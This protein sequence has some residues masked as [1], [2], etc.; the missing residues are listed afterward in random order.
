MTRKNPVVGQQETYT[1]ADLVDENIQR[2]TFGH[3]YY[4]LLNT[5][6]VLASNYTEGG[7][8]KP[9]FLVSWATHNSI[10]WTRIS[11]DGQQIQMVQEMVQVMVQQIR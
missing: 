11:A 1:P 2:F 6:E 10:S 7:T 5:P 8:P 9:T 3:I 4:T